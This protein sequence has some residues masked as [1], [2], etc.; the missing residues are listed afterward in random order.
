MTKYYICDIWNARKDY[1]VIL[2]HYA[3]IRKREN[4]CKTSSGYFQV[5]KRI[6]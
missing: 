1:K 6:S 5:N 3:P 4:L 2:S